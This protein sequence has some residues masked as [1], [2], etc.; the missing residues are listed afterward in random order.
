MGLLF[1][2]FL[3]GGCPELTFAANTDRGTVVVTTPTM[4]TATSVTMVAAKPDRST[5]LI[6]NDSAANICCSLTGAILAGIVPTSTNLCFVIPAG[7][8]YQSPPNMAT[9]DAVTC[10]QTS[11]GTINTVYVHQG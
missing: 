2:L 10:Y 5:L 4:T 3:V 8:C 6:Q 11:G 1:F 9:T 7:G